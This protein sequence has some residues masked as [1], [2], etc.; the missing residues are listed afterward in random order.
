MTKGITAT[1]ALVGVTIICW[2]LTTPG[3]DSG[4]MGRLTQLLGGLAL[5]GF[6]IL[7]LISSR[8]PIIDALFHGLDK[9]YVVHKWMGIITIGV[10][11][12]HLITHS[13]AHMAGAG[14]GPRGGPGGG[15][16][17]GG[18]GGGPG[19][20]GP[21]ASPAALLGVLALI[22][23]VILVVLA[24]KS[25][26]SHEV[27]KR[28]HMLMALPYCVGL[29][30]YY[31]ASQY[32]PWGLNP[33]SVWLMIVNLVGVVA[34]IYSVL[35][36]ERLAFRH[37][38][39]ITSLRTVGQGNLEITASPATKELS[40]K[41]G[42]FT[43]IKF[44][45]LTGFTSHPFT[46]ANAPG[47][48]TIQF[49]IRGLG[50]HTTKL[51]EQLAVG[52]RLVATKAHGR[53]NYTSGRQ[54]GVVSPDTGNKIHQVWIA[55]GIGI[56]PFRSFIQAGI[57]SSHVIDFFYTFHGDQ[58]AYLDELAEISDNLRIHL[59]DTST[60]A[61]LSV[62]AIITQVEPA[63][64]TD[65]YYCGPAGLKTVLRQGFAQL[66]PHPYRFHAEEFKFG[67]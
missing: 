61:K 45:G 18:P 43:F 22:G 8:I 12:I 53:F 13:G 7:F 33:Y 19:G 35:L 14:R 41:P 54:I 51:P 62:Q 10:V 2:A 1:L 30:H 9:A 31:L 63:G 65:I 25:H 56:T 42:Q 29:V 4:M 60:H 37:K 47:A 6:S 3:V 23:F 48:G 36:Y 34:L 52:D 58:A 26:N 15:P 49:A 27:W 59:I 55:G 67:G 44:P 64:P 28:T 38:Y 20:G 46:I 5:L 40:W 32:D 66:W 11:I 17:G 21:G 39:A 16:F 57:P 24:L 50:D